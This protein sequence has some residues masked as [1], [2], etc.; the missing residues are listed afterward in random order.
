MKAGRMRALPDSMQ[1]LAE[2]LNEWR[3]PTWLLGLLVALLGW[4]LGFA[5]PGPGLDPSWW[6]GLYMATDQGMQFG[7]QVVFTYGPLGFL[8]L[9]WLWFSGLASIAFIY[10][11]AI[12][13]AFSCALVWTFRVRLGAPIACLISVLILAGVA[14]IN[15]SIA[16]AALWAFAVLSKHPPRHSLTVLSV[17]GA[18]DDFKRYGVS[19]RA[20][21]VIDMIKR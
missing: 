12:Y 15:Y 19:S 2:A 9:P 10:S 6:A 16:L 11:A 3:V 21:S 20:S 4:R 18:L 14:G 5:L 7:T 1:R 8:G 17:A 13:L